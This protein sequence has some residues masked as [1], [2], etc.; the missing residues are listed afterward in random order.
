MA[1]IHE[2]ST[3]LLD[4]IKDRTFGN[5][6]ASQETYRGLYAAVAQIGE[7]TRLTEPQTALDG[8]DGQIDE[9]EKALGELVPTRPCGLIRPGSRRLRAQA[10]QAA[11]R[12]AGRP[13]NLARKPL[14]SRTGPA[15][16]GVRFAFPSRDPI[17]A[18]PGCESSEARVYAQELGNRRHMS[19]EPQ[20]WMPRSW[21]EKVAGAY[22]LGRMIDKGRRELAS[23]EA[24]MDL[25]QPYQF[26][27][28]NPTDG[29]ML[30]VMRLKESHVVEAM[31]AHPSDD[32]A[33]GAGILARAGW[34]PTDT[35]RWN[36]WFALL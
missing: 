14:P 26:G 22:W 9:A 21:S 11:S 8:L 23:D 19:D 36:K 6:T 5:D 2:S 30:F 10:W 31:L 29:I 27:D 3:A 24:G 15:T 20:T 17:L 25:L 18:Q 12:S 34:T 28:C 13:V 4:G 16:L 33:A 32:E 1:A 35:D 7:V